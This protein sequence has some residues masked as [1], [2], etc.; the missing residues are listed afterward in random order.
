[1]ALT[2]VVVG[3]L[4][5]DFVIR[6]AEFPLPGQTLVADEFRVFPGGKGANQAYACGKLGAAVSMIGRVGSDGQ[7]EGLRRNLADVNVNVDHVQ[8]VAGI[9][10]GVATITIDGHGQ[11]Q[12]IIV[13]GANGAFDVTQLQRSAPVIAKAGILLLQLEIPVETVLAA[14]QVGRKSGAIVILDP[15]PA[16]KL[17]DELLACADYLTPNETELAVLAGVPP[18]AWSPREAS[19]IA[20]KLMDRGAR[21]IIVKMGSQ[22]A[23]LVTRHEEHF[24]PARPVK[25]VDSTAAG[26]AFNGAFAAALAREE[27]EIEAGAFATAAAALSVTRAG[28]QP[29]MPSA[30]EVAAFLRAG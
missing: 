11:N 5:A 24:W 4:N 12:I 21:K 22:G 16:R 8:S 23:V 25:A 9:S 3:S 30:D 1:M 13:P 14:A 20:R 2:V 17:P 28:A 19:L 27:S 26:D 7:A 6:V 10:T 18:A 15:A 29:S